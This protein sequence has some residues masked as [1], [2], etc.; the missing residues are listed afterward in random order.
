VAHALALRAGKAGIP[1]FTLQHGFENIGLSYKDLV[2]GS[3]VRFAS[4]NV[5]IWFAA[6]NLPAWVPPDTFVR[7]IPTGSPKT[8]SPPLVA[9][10]LPDLGSWSRKIGVFEN[11]HW[12]RF[13]E[14]YKRE[15]LADLDRAAER[16]P[17]TLFLIKPHSAGRWLVRN[18]FL[19]PMR[20]NIRFINPLEPEWQIFT[21]PALIQHLDATITTPSTV[22]VDAARAARPVAV[23]GYDLDLPLYAP[24]P[25]LSRFDDWCAFIDQLGDAAASLVRN[26]TFLRRNFLPY[27][28]Q[29]R[30]ADAMYVIA[31]E[32]RRRS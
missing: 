28:G 3:D 16:F 6:E 2:F 12:H 19:V 24:L 20:Q 27:A 9:H 10:P 32:K 18:S 5:F 14:S 15:F 13:S 7:I 21:A 25:V 8:M 22:A 26:E 1:T 4:G 11:L 29:Y 23:L 17:D 31:T 30:M